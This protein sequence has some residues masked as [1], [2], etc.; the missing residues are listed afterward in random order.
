MQFEFVGIRVFL[1]CLKTEIPGTLDYAADGGDVFLGELEESDSVG[2]VQGD[3]GKGG[4]EGGVGW[5]FA[6]GEMV[7][8]FFEG[9]GIHRGGFDGR[10]EF[11]V[12][13]RS[14]VG[15][16]GSGGKCSS[17]ELLISFHA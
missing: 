14:C 11:D 5:Y 1:L 7:L 12:R 10:R 8:G 17:I 15:V 16:D 6:G 4:A 2:F 3:R 13:L 9:R